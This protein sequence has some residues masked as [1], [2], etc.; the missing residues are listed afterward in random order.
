MTF[1]LALLTSVILLATNVCIFQ[2]S[3]PLYFWIAIFFL[4]ISK[5]FWTA[6]PNFMASLKIWSL[7]SSSTVFL[8]LVL[9]LISS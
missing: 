3:R 6:A 7:A 1:E 4:Y 2:A 5:N 8:E 9:F